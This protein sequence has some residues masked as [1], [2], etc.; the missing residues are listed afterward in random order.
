MALFYKIAKDWARF[1]TMCTNLARFGKIWGELA[2]VGGLYATRDGFCDIGQAFGR[3][4]AISLEY[5]GLRNAC[6]VLNFEMHRVA[7]AG[8]RKI[9]HDLEISDSD[10]TWRDSA[11]TGKI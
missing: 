9:R 5:P 4:G 1:G 8:F 3:F 6:R 10:M 7:L 11:R 2:G